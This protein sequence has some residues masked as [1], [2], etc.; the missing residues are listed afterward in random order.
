MIN[1][2]NLILAITFLSFS[3]LPAYAHFSLDEV[4]KET[5]TQRYNMLPSVEDSN[6]SLKLSPHF[7]GFLGKAEEVVTR[8]E[9]EPYVGLRL[10]H[11][12]FPV[13]QNQLMVE[14]Y[15]LIEGTPSLVTYAHDFDLASDKGAV[16]ASWIFST[17]E[18][19]PMVFETS[20]DFAV[21]TGVR[22][23]QENYEFMEEM[24][25]LLKKSSLSH[26]LSVALLRRDSLNVGDQQIYMEINDGDSR[27]SV[28]QLWSV[29]D[30]NNAIRTTWSFKGPKQQDCLGTSY[31]KKTSNGHIAANIHKRK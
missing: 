6:D 11:N 3:N 4:D 15:Q 30:T 9:F 25:P 23:L 16:P 26:I 5:Y 22:H 18:F 28:V 20:T 13:D 24:G 19:E 29:N 21:K 12:H 7:L 10:I 1:K 2:K 31:C 17:D 14:E 27:K 8:Y